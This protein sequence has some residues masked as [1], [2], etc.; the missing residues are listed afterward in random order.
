MSCLRMAEFKIMS[1]NSKSLS[2][3]PFFEDIVSVQQN[4]ANQ[5]QFTE[6]SSNDSDN[7]KFIEDTTQIPKFLSNGVDHI[8]VPKKLK[9]DLKRHV[10]QKLLYNIDENLNIAIEKCLILASNLSSTYFTDFD[11]CW[12]SL[13]SRILH[14]QTKSDK[15]NTYVYNHI[16]RALMH[17]TTKNGGIIEVKENSS[18]HATYQ[19]GKTSKKYRFTPTYLNVGLEKYQLQNRY[20]IKKRGS[21]F[22]NQINRAKSNPIC[23]NLLMLYPKI[24]LP[25]DNELIS[26]GKRLVKANHKTKKGKILTFR[27]KKTN[28]YWKDSNNRSFV[29]DD[30]KMFNYL[31]KI[32]YLI[33]LEGSEASGRRVVDSFVLIPSWIRNMI[34]IDGNNTKEVD[35]SCF[36][37]NIA[38]KIYG[39]SG[40]NINHTTV[41]EY[42]GIPT[43]TAKI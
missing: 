18:G 23:S 36:H 42:L 25:T 17:G 13:S 21:Y 9:V 15:D 27:N 31:T 41:A 2:P 32:S 33:P 11:D 39:G 29:E 34:K 40:K 35:Y 4:L 28:S 16:I 22:I 14:E 38:Q 6:T 1:P 30:I 7:L 3:I 43:R 26:E 20:Y 5:L 24:T 8:H 37:P 19:V 12:K 10:P